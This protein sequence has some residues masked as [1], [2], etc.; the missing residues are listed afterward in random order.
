[1]MSVLTCTQGNQL[2]T[3]TVRQRVT[4]TCPAADPQGEGGTRQNGEN[5]QR[6]HLLEVPM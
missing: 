2:G 4:T 6:T 1:M 3:I 5:N